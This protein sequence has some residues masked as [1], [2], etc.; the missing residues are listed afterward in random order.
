MPAF[1]E[2]GK[3]DAL[4]TALADLCAAAEAAVR[5]DAAGCLV[6]SDR[7]D[8]APLSKSRVPIPTLLAVGAVHHHLIAAGLRSDTSIVAETAQAFST[9]HIAVLVGYGAHAVCPYLAFES[10]RQWRASPR[11]STLIKNG[12]IPAITAV[13]AQRNFKKALEKGVLK[14]LSKM[15]ISLLSCYH[16]AQIFE[17]YGLG[18]EVVDIAFRGSVSRIGGLSFADLQVCVQLVPTRRLVSRVGWGPVI[19]QAERRGKVLGDCAG[20]GCCDACVYVRRGGSLGLHCGGLCL[21]LPAI[22]L[23]SAEPARAWSRLCSG[24]CTGSVCSIRSDIG[25][26]SPRRGRAASAILHCGF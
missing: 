12:R 8:D 20:A 2:G 24:E 19:A 21:E 14:I 17:A 7:D 23:S 13:A 25:S 15:G 9:H 1:F 16:G 11:T 10:V 6:L 22:A 18:R 26:H 3:P 5:D 4:K